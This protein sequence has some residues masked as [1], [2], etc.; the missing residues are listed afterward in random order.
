LSSARPVTRR[1]IAA[2]ADRQ[3]A[4]HRDA[5]PALAARDP[6]EGEDGAD[7]VARILED[8]D[9]GRL[10]A[11]AKPDPGEIEAWLR[12]TVAGLVTWEGWEAIDRH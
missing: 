6:R 2:R 9:V 12:A 10:N 5:L 4:P 3:V 7:T 8:R 1:T 11:P